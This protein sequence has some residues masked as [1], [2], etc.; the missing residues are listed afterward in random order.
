[1]D[2]VRWMKSNEV[3][4]FYASRGRIGYSGR[5]YKDMYLAQVKKPSESKRRWDDL[6]MIATT[7]ASDAFR[8]ESQSECKNAP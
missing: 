4:D 8:P 2:A 1:M 7:P 3:R 6:K 5:L